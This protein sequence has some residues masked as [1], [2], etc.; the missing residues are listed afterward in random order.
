MSAA[1]P[2]PMGTAPSSGL[3]RRT[4]QRQAL[5][6][7]S[8]RSQLGRPEVNTAGPPAKRSDSQSYAANDSSDDEIPV[9]MKLSALT[10]A[11]L[12]DGPATRRP[13]S[14]PRTRRR[15]SNLAASTSSA[16]EERRHLRSGSVQALEQKPSRPA[17]PHK[18]KES[19]EASPVRKRVIRLSNTGRDSGFGQVQPE[20]RRSITTRQASRDTLRS[21]RTSSQHEARE[22]SADEQ[23]EPQQP[24]VYTPQ[25]QGMR[26]VR[27][28]AS[29]AS[30]R[31]AQGPSSASRRSISNVDAEAPVE[32]AIRDSA[33]PSHGSDQAHSNG[34]R[35]V[36]IEDNLALQSS[37]RVKRVGKVPG[38][39]LSGPARRGRRRQSEEEAE[40]NGEPYAM[41]SSQDPDGLAGDLQQDPASSFYGNGRDFASGS[42]VAP[43]ESS[44]ATHRRQMSDALLESAARPAPE[45]EYVPEVHIPFR[46]PSRP[47]MPS[48]H[49]Q[50][51]EPQSVFK[52]SQNKIDLIPQSEVKEIPRR[53]A[54][55]DISNR[56]PSPDRKALASLASNTPR[57]PAPPPPPKMSVLQAATNTAHTGSTSQGKQRRNVLRVNGKTYSRLDCLGRGGSAKVYRVTAENGTMFALKRVSLEQAD[58]MT[59]KGY[60]GEIDLLGK[61]TTVDRVINLYDW[62]LNDEKKM[63][64]LLMEL[65]ERDLNS[66]LKDRQNPEAAKF[67]PAFV[68]FYWKEMLECLQSVHQFDVVH[69]DLK[70]A[71]F[72]LVQGRLKL[73]DFGIANAIETDETVNVHRETQIGTPNYMSPE[74]LM[75]FNAP[76]GARVPGRPKLMK[77]G[78]PSDIWSLGCILYQM[79]YGV[80][81]F[82]H[83]VNQMARCQAIINWDHAIEF[84]ARGMGGVPVPPSLLRTLKRCLNREIHMRPTS[85]E[86]LHETDPF[87]YPMELPDRALPIDEDLLGRI[88][89]SV[90]SRCRDNMPTEAEAKT[91]W[92]GAYW[93]SVKKATEMSRMS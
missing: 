74:S 84:P 2:T 51:N 5:R 80:P 53:P 11:L 20:K 34:A 27:I 25:S 40:A 61:L 88:I 58:P 85:E 31:A 26:V 32:P 75:D 15:T 8:S 49:D 14:P 76:R 47:H 3:V 93:Q 50:E 6:R 39:F 29:S 33:P 73:I 83:I 54:S 16:S 57:R 81:P 89:Q 67:D 1:S 35:S 13:V 86:L 65:G 38:S 45:D 23:A 18:N 9:P 36:K 55:V 44:R 22:Q 46:L 82:G 60:R 66:M 62:E 77:L 90:V 24:N 42:P 4:S 71:N 92:P 28:S 19:R 17:S 52:R 72:V 21:S 59:I 68:R 48:G 87:L 63:L 91:I 41:A 56:H 69:S 12:N 30:R 7:P 37:M 64:T 43:K 10:K 78:K 79:V 70:P